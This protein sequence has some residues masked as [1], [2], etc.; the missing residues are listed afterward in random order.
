MFH[1]IP[2]HSAP[3]G[4]KFGRFDGADEITTAY[5]ERIV[6]LPLYFGLSEDEQQ[7]VIDAVLSFY[8]ERESA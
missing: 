1:Y 2:L 3:A 6:R 8:G 4:Q 7:K 5:S